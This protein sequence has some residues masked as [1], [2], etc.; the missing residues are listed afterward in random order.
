MLQAYRGNEPYIYISYFHKDRD[1]AEPIIRKLQEDGYRVSFDESPNPGEE[2]TEDVDRKIVG[3]A[4]FITLLSEQ[5][6]RMV[7]G[8]VEFFYAMQL[9]KKI[10]PI[11]PEDASLSPDVEFYLNGYR[12]IRLDQYPDRAGFLADLYRVQGISD[13]RDAESQAAPRSVTWRYANGNV[14]EGEAV[15][16]KRHGHGIL[17]FADG[18]VYEGAFCEDAQSGSGRMCYA[19]G[20]CTRVNF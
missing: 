9:E 14:Y 17:R 2:F 6:S 7:C 20:P 15:G 13:C 12:S 16:G 3:C 5:Y 18:S 8:K 4:L 10:L 11:L 1:V 19:D